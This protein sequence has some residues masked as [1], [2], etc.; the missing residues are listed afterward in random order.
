V[1]IAA[2]VNAIWIATAPQASMPGRG[3]T[4]ALLFPVANEKAERKYAIA[5]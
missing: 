4:F 2:N 1:S 3:S 5:H